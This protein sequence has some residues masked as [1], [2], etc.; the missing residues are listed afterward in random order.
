[1]SRRPCQSGC[2]MNWHIQ[3]DMRADCPDSAT[4]IGH[5]G[6]VYCLHH[7]AARI[8]IEHCRKMQ[9]WECALIIQVKQLPPFKPITKA[10]YLARLRAAMR[11]AP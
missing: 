6:F 11:R 8:G 3:C 1:M 4:Y 2:G 9:K 10:A 7:T 5:K